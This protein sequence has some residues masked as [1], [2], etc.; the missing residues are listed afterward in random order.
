MRKLQPDFIVFFLFHF[1]F[2]LLWLNYLTLSKAGFNC[3]QILSAILWTTIVEFLMSFHVQIS[4]VLLAGLYF[5]STG[6]ILQRSFCYFD[7]KCGNFLSFFKFN[8]MPKILTEV[9]NIS[10]YLPSWFW[11]KLCKIQ[12][13]N[14]VKI[15]IVKSMLYIMFFYCFN[16]S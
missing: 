3:N 5:P 10:D 12:I 16:T 4:Y 13:K 7:T 9:D 14:S 6:G 1:S 11:R 8:L 15:V 2:L